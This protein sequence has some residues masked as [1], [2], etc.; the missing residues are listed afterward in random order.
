MIV[1][2]RKMLTEQRWHQQMFDIYSLTPRHLGIL[3]P[4]PSP[5]RRRSSHAG[6]PGLS[7]GLD[8]LPNAY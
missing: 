5:P 7:F 1:L 4:I 3:D 8:R 6:L 2:K